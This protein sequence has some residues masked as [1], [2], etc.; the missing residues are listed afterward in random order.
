MLKIT[1]KVLCVLQSGRTSDKPGTATERARRSEW[2]LPKAWI[3]SCL[4]PLWLSAAE[5]SL[6]RESTSALFHS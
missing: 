6:W 1:D 3:A 5:H 4:Q 2:S